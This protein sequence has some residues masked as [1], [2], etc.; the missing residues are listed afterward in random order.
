MGCVL[1]LLKVG[2]W[3]RV[4]SIHCGYCACWCEA[5]VHIPYDSTDGMSEKQASVAQHRWLQHIF[6]TIVQTVT[7]YFEK[8]S[9]GAMSCTSKPAKDGASQPEEVQKFAKDGARKPAE[10]RELAKEIHAEVQD[11]QVQR[12]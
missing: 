6:R 11:P 12:V 1:E 8:Q 2:H 4:Y 5:T 3:C 7:S 10:V 9:R